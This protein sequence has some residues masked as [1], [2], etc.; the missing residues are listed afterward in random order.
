MIRAIGTA[1]RGTPENE[2]VLSAIAGEAAGELD[3]RLLT[4]L[5]AHDRTLPLEYHPTSNRT[6]S[7]PG[8]RVAPR[9]SHGL[10]RGVHSRDRTGKQEAD[11]DDRLRVFAGSASVRLGAEVCEMLEV[12]PAAYECRRFPDG[13]M[14]IEDAGVGWWV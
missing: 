11:V 7:A 14:Q 12:A 10:A 13:E 5:E 1:P 9:S 4:I 8:A 2:R 3:C 6:A